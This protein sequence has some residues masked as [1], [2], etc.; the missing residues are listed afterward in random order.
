[1]IKIQLKKI[2]RNETWKSA[3]RNIALFLIFL[4]K[5]L[6]KNS[7]KSEPKKIFFLHIVYVQFEKISRRILVTSVVS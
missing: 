4:R 2:W 1:M 6:C 5:K 3:I 7:L